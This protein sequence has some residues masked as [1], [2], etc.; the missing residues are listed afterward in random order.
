[1]DSSNPLSVNEFCCPEQV[2]SLDMRTN[3]LKG[4]GVRVR[5][6]GTAHLRQGWEVDL[7][8]YLFHVNLGDFF[9]NKRYLFLFYILFWSGLLEGMNSL[10][11]TQTCI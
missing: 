2:I 8:F 11:F 3:L 7:L 4:P 9:V 10:Q 1:M 6:G 5:E